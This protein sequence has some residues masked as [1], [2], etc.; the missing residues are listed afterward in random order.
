MEFSTCVSSFLSLFLFA[1]VCLS[2]S[3]SGGVNEEWLLGWKNLLISFFG[4]WKLVFI[5]FE[6]DRESGVSNYDEYS[7][8][9]GEKLVNF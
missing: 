6:R 4:L 5:T 8:T 2:N 7:S 3:H 1:A 9:L